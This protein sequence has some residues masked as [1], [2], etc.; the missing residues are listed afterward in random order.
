[1]TIDFPA[2]QPTECSYTPPRFP[3]TE[4]V[5]RSGVRSYRIW[6]NKRS[7]GFLDLRFE[8]ID[9][10]SAAAILN[11]FENAKGIVEDLAL[12]SILFNSI[13][14]PSLLAEFSQSNSDLKWYFINDEPPIMERVQGG[15]RYT[16][17]V[18]LRAELRFS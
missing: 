5:S 8:N 17:R 7:D 6:A 1:M 16:T 13:T 9:Q 12:P 14:N 15:K 18:R 2:I 4:S 3:T 11:T 10:V